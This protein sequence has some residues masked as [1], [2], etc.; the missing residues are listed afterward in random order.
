MVNANGDYVMNL[1]SCGG[2]NRGGNSVGVATI[3]IRMGVSSISTG[4]G[5]GIG[6]SICNSLDRGSNGGGCGNSVDIGCCHRCRGCYGVNV[7]SNSTFNMNIRNLSINI[8][9]SSDVFM[10]VSLSRD[11]LMYVGLSS[12]ILM[13]VFLGS[14]ILM[15][16]GLSINLSVNVGFSSRIN[17]SSVVIR[18]YN[19]GGCVDK[20]GRGS[21]GIVSIS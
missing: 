12:D 21:S 19:N 10:Y 17:L 2:S 11:I 5:V 7:G 18:I 6:T 1:F 8:G 16:I 3:G 14:D 4:I 20:W 9:L 15:N 13:F